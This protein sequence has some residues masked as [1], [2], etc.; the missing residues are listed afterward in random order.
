L[1]EI[2]ERYAEQRGF[3]AKTYDVSSE[4][5]SCM[6]FKSN[7]IKFN[8]KLRKTCIRYFMT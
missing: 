8:S 4:T 5:Q 7:R 3:P 6:S 1:D 2:F